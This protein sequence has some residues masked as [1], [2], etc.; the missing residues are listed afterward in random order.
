MCW[1]L[2]EVTECVCASYYFHNHHK[3]PSKGLS[4]PFDVKRSKI[5]PVIPYSP[6]RLMMEPAELYTLSFCQF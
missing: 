2:R 6:R 1:H 5:L 3:P 4:K